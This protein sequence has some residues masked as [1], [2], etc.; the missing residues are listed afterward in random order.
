MGVGREVGGRGHLTTKSYH[1]MLCYITIQYMKAA[2]LN[3]IFL[4]GTPYKPQDVH[5]QLLYNNSQA[6]N[7]IPKLLLASYMAGYLATSKSGP[8]PRLGS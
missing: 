8:M 6:N 1:T 2:S 3:G 4:S 7:N 5:T